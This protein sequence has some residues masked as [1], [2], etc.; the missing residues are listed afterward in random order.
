MK[1]TI[2][3]DVPDELAKILGFGGTAGDV[4]VTQNAPAEP[5]NGDPW[6]SYTT[7]PGQATQQ[8]AQNVA[9][10]DQVAPGGIT[11]EALAAAMKLLQGAAGGQSGA[12]SGST[13]GVTTFQMQGKNGM[14][15]WTLNR[16]DAPTCQC[17]QPAAF[18]TGTTNG[19]S[20]S[21]WTCVKKRNP[22][23]KSACKFNQFA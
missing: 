1:Y 22:D 19:K 20:W 9:T 6:N 2:T 23:D 7:A 18:V 8:A 10:A 21:R 14:T 17:N 13:G 5:E 4:T 3:V 16:G 15:N 12:T 11:P